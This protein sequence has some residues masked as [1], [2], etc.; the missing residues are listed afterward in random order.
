[1]QVLEV[2]PRERSRISVGELPIAF[3]DASGSEEIKPRRQDRV[4]ENRFGC[5]G[6]GFGV[7]ICLISLRAEEVVSRESSRNSKRLIHTI[8]HFCIVSEAAL[9]QRL[10]VM[11]CLRRLRQLAIAGLGAHI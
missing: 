10:F 5:Y 4:V 8:F 7:G 6:R 9:A 1:M 11:I 3:M 2:L